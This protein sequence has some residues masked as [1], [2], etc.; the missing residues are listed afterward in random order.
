[1]VIGR[2]VLAEE[3]LDDRSRQDV[4]GLQDLVAGATR[5]HAD[6]HGDLLAGVQD[7]GGGLKLLGPRNDVRREIHGLRLRNAGSAEPTWIGVRVGRSLLEVDRQREVRDPL[8]GQRGLHRDVDHGRDAHRDHDHLV[9][10]AEVHERLVQ[11]NLLLVLGAEL[12]RRLHP[13]DGEHRHVIQ[14]R[15]VQPI[16]Q[17]DAARTAGHTSSGLG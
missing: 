3:R 13:G 10:D 17:M 11:V 5:T 1:M 4:G 14:L 15:V 9:V 8:E 6:Q 16:H 2:H 7:V 12:R